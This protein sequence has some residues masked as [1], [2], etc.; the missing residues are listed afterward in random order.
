MG[1]SFF[2]S[3]ICMVSTY[4]VGT[5]YLKQHRTIEQ[6]VLHWLWLYKVR[7]GT[8]TCTVR[9]TNASPVLV[10]EAI[11]V[12]HAGE[13]V[14]VVLVILVL[15]V[16]HCYWYLV[17][18]MLSF[19]LPSSAFVVFGLLS[20]AVHDFARLPER[21]ASD[22]FSPQMGAWSMMGTYYILYD[23]TCFDCGVCLSVVVCSFLWQGT[24]R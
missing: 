13:R 11:K 6:Q 9:S 23:T 20:C 17:L 22:G 15:F 7:Y 19:S 14:F 5:T 12:V 2:I 8:H 21:S 18:E 24:I 3:E 10:A 4:W 1:T 16:C